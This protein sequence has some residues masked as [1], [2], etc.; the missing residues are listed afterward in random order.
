MIIWQKWITRQDLQS[1]PGILYIFGDNEIRRGLGGQ[2]KEMRGEPNAV[3]V[4]TL[5]APGTF[6]TENDTRRQCFVIDTD[7]SRIIPNLLLNQ[8]VIWPA[9]NIGTGL[10]HL[11]RLAPTTFAH[12]LAR[13]NQ[14]WK[15]RGT[16]ELKSK[17]SSLHAFH[18]TA[19]QTQRM[20]EHLTCTDA[21]GKLYDYS[22]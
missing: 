7:L 9:D 15:L 16:D 2:A 4:A 18:R 13:R 14:L 17:F 10:A 8:P 6:W 11:D 21:R 22:T 12:L 5:A 20:L 1:N 19:E 3:G